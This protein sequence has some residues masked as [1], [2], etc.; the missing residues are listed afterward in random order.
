M[1]APSPFAVLEEIDELEVEVARVDAMVVAERAAVKAARRARR[2][3]G[4]PVGARH[5]P[6]MGLLLGAVVGGAAWLASE[7]DVFF[8]VFVLFAGTFAWFVK[9]SA[10]LPRKDGR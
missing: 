8:V 7:N 2:D 9:M 3:A 6:A 4:P 5:W 10:E 1:T